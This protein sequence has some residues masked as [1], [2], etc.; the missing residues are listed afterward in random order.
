[1]LHCLVED[2]KDKMRRPLGQQ[3]KIKQIY[4]LFLLSFVIY[5]WTLH[6]YPDQLRHLKLQSFL[7]YT[8]H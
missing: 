6:T 4:F 8:W 2:D 1:M 5:F 3:L 7:L